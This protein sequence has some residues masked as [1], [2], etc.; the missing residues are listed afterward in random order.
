MLCRFIGRVLLYDS[1]SCGPVDQ[2]LVCQLLEK[3]RVVFIA[4]KMTD[5]RLSGHG[6][7]SPLSF[8]RYERDTKIS[9]ARMCTKGSK[10]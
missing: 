9:N 8:L 6:A 7:R 4:G 5:P 3:L 2:A 10:P 1:K